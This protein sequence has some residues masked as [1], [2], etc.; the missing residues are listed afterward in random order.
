MAFLWNL[1]KPNR[2]QESVQEPQS[3]TP[4]QP[5][6]TKKTKTPWQTLVDEE[7]ASGN[8]TSHDVEL[9]HDVE[10]PEILD[11][12]SIVANLKKKARK[13]CLKPKL[14]ADRL[15]RNKAFEEFLLKKFD[16]RTFK[17]LERNGL[18][19]QTVDKE[20]NVVTHPALVMSVGRTDTP[21]SLGLECKWVAHKPEH[22]LVC[23]GKT[24]LARAK[25][26]ER[27]TNIPVFL[28]VAVAGTPEQP[29]HLYV[30]PA[31]DITSNHL[32]NDQLIHYEKDMDE[33][34]HFDRKQL[35]LY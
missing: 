9:L 26:F 23:A 14:G 16:K 17:V 7:F 29:E 20:H 10:L 34:F 2:P 27:E 3:A 1:I 31:R 5:E 25:V 18:F 11:C 6:T 8:I 22:G 28:I 24:V 35:K 13:K 32:R 15:E 19:D 12:D 30:I 4:E 21:V 33:T